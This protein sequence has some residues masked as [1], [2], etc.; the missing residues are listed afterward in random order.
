MVLCEKGKM[1]SQNL[2]KIH[3]K[4][5]VMKSNKVA[6]LQ[7]HVTCEKFRKISFAEHLREAPSVLRLD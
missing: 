5:V 4:T 3:R 7:A 2:R 6:V 1:C